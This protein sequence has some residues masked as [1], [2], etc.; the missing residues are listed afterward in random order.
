MND[1]EL[2]VADE[3]TGDLDRKS[4]EEIL[5]L[6]EKLSHEFGKTIIMVTHDAR[7]ALRA[8]VTHYLEKGQLV[9]SMQGSSEASLTASESNATSSP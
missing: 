4:S 5:H 6:L 3:P 1:P 9:E 8:R 7:A 2:I